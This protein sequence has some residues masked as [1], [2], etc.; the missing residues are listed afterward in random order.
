MVWG[1]TGPQ[2]SSDG[3]W[4]GPGLSARC[5]LGVITPQTAAVRSRTT[6][7][8]SAPSGVRTFPDILTRWEGIQDKNAIYL[9]CWGLS[10]PTLFLNRI[11]LQTFPSCSN[12]IFVCFS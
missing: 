6:P 2:L 5:G 4:E 7:C 10:P 11:Q 9:E 12:C 3:D 8:S 1:N